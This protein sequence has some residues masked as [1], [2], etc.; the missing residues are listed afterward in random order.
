MKTR[1]RLALVGL[2]LTA[3]G[4]IGLLLWQNRE[5]G[6]E[7]WLWLAALLLAASLAAGAIIILKQHRAEAA[8]YRPLLE[9]AR[10]FFQAVGREAQI[11]DSRTLLLS[12]REGQRTMTARCCLGDLLKVEEIQESFAH[13]PKPR[14]GETAESYLVFPRNLD[15]AANRQLDVYRL[16]ERVVIVP[17]SL[18]YLTARVAE[19]PA[20]A[21]QALD[22]LHRRY[23]GKQDLFDMRNALD[24]ARFFFG[25]RSLLSEIVDTLSRRE[26]VALVGPRKVGK[27]SVLNLLVQRL[28]EFPVVHLDLQLYQRGDED[29]PSKIL[30]AILD[31]YDRWGQTRFRESW[32]SNRSEGAATTGPEFRAALQARRD[33]QRSLGN[34]RP[35]VLLCDEIER[36]FPRPET[37]NRPSGEVERFL[38]LASVLRA[39]GQQSGDRLLSMVIA[40]RLPTFNRVNELGG[41]GSETNPFYRFFREVFL[42]PLEESECTEMLTEI[43]GAMG[44]EL[45]PDVIKMV[46]SDSG[47]YPSLARLLASAAYQQ[48]GDSAHLTLE[49][50]ERGL[51]QMRE[52][53]GESD[54]FFR[55][56]L[57][58][59]VSGPEKRLLVLASADDG[60]GAETLA[61]ASPVPV[62]EGIESS[63]SASVGLSQL[64][65]SRRL[66][67]AT[68]MLEEIDQKY[69]VRGALFRAWLRENVLTVSYHPLMET[70]RTFFL[71]VGREVQIV[72]YRTLIVEGQISMLIRCC[73][74]DLLRV[75]EVQEAFAVLPT[76]REG[77]TI[78]SY[79]VF[80]HDLDPAAS[81]QLDVYRLREHA[82]IVPLSLAYL[83]AKVAEGPDAARQALD[84][85]H[86]R[87]LGKQDLFDMRNALDEAR[88]F[89][90]RRSLLSEIVDTLSRREHV[91]LVGPRK[92]G[93]S[94]V[95]NL[96][97]QRLDEFP[98][99]HLD[100]QLYQRADEDWPGKILAAILDKYDRWG[101]TR[102]GESW[103]PNRSEGAATT[104]PEFRAALQARRDRQRRLGN[105]RP[106]VLLCD[107]IE[108]IFPRPE[109]LGRSS[110]EVER[111]LYLS[112]VLRAL[113]QQSGD[114][115]LAMVIADRL[116]TFNRVNELGGEGSETNPFYR[117]FRE[118][119]LGPLEEAECAQM[120][121]EIGHAMGLEIDAEVIEAVFRDSGGYPS[122]ARLLASAAYQ[123]RGDSAHLTLGHYERGLEQMREETGES[124]NYFRENLW[125][126]VSGPEK[127]LL[128]LASAENG[129][130]TEILEAPG[131]VPLLEG[132]ESSGSAAAG[133]SQLLDA[134]RLLLATGMLEEID[135]R[136]RVRGALFRLWLREYIRWPETT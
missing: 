57:W 26:H 10:T 17:L 129:T 109:S 99:V 127:R 46:F 21:R 25:R 56:N 87:Y 100:L 54:N 86:R 105:D 67:L 93:K 4:V 119:F 116:P 134:R 11:I 115:L 111:F 22:D 3:A 36:I 39:L 88:F 68:G 84:D 103:S 83:T 16:R 49:H 120:L 19:G 125:Q 8:A 12:G 89:F 28:D 79:L 114:R 6:R 76:P 27:S 1:S 29:W 85:L 131:P 48:R 122:L 66:L 34:D 33:R 42:G 61:A 40:D 107:E 94:S 82:V 20:A 73:L 108:R 136:Y 47:G 38:Y 101:Q 37:L 64:L 52:E 35:L 78:E 130:P 45:N 102:F 132:V 133:R 31:K 72:D 2:G 63:G 9:S 113:G 135:Q 30:A 14:A 62:L 41:E 123:Q 55:Q 69:R 50:Y 97:V 65:D 117:F 124:D 98:V 96:L 80:P 126:A 59:A 110:G 75:E 77:E 53:T 95:L 118:V 18:A 112:S 7:E 121:T 23:L 92:V 71:A 5:R 74:G 91:A 24:E 43:G 70:A 128:A 15:P 60:T 90:G 51:V 81:R 44:L 106:L 13:L 58:Q 32:G 104:G